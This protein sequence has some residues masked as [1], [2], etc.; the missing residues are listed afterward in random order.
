MMARATRETRVYVECAQSHPLGSNAVR[1]ISPRALERTSKDSNFHFKSFSP[2]KPWFESKDLQ[3]H[4]TLK[5]IKMLE[6][7]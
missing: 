2:L 4:K 5:Q 1:S 7:N 3:H 6:I